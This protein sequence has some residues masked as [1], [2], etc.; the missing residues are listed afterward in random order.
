MPFHFVD[1]ALKLYH[2]IR[3][4]LYFILPNPYNSLPFMEFHH[5][6]LLQERLFGRV[7]AESYF[8]DLPSF[9]SNP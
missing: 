9:M 8:L 4:S 6:S 2:N 1:I 7:E 3:Y 5:S